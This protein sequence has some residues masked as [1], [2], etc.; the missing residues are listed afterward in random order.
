MDK[1]NI[2]FVLDIFKTLSNE[3]PEQLLFRDN[4]DSFE[5]R[6]LDSIGSGMPSEMHGEGWSL[7]GCQPA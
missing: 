5:L 2:D 3:L 6:T 4:G 7:I 1:N